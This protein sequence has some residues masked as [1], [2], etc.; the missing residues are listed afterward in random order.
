[1]KK[2]LIKYKSL[3]VEVKAALWF[4]VCN[5]INKAISMIIVPIYTRLLTT[6][7]YGTYTVFQSWLNLFI[8]L[9]T[10]EIGRG[11]YS[12]GIMKYEDDSDRYSSAMLGL[13]NA[14][15]ILF[16]VVYLFAIPFF[17]GVLEMNTSLVMS[18]FAYL[19]FYPA[20][21]FWCIK[22]RFAYKYK[23]MVFGTLIVAFLSPIIGVVGIVGLGLKSEAAILSK[24][25]VQGIA[26]LGVYVLFLKKS[27][28]PFIKVYWKEVLPYSLTLLP[29]LLSTMIL[30]QADRLM[31]NRM[32][33]TSEAAIY[34]VAYSVSM[35]T[36]LLNTAINNA[37]VPWMYR[38]LKGK[39]Y[40]KIEPV[41]DGLQMIVGIINLTLIVFAPEVIAAFA[42]PQYKEAIF[43]I[44]PIT[45]S[46]YFMF[47]FQRY[48]NVEMYYEKTVS[49][50]IMSIL[51]ALFNIVLNYFCILKWGYLAAG[52]TTLVSYILFCI[53][54]YFIVYKIE[55]IKCEG[56]TIFHAK[57]T[58]LAGIGFLIIS[59]GIMWLYNYA[60][61]RYIVA[62]GLAVI[63]YKKK[64]V[65]MWMLKN[66]KQDTE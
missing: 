34:S 44:P 66:K 42:P 1:M 17:N 13:S 55:K 29:Y 33:G 21:E 18:M 38:R 53:G 41:A 20:W 39:Q 12:L 56:N 31:I 23:R 28:T 59:F 19:L 47:I 25:V 27:P 37:F 35:L 4:V 32:V 51:V 62:A 61:V 22:Q 2:L 15:T 64:D 3:S 50:S 26:A 63:A 45:A 10:L 43:I 46:V 65:F 40:N 24:L 30:N 52:Y 11:H 57:R 14:T 48:I 58:I 49:I 16:L 8:I 9:M 5:F 54:H 36:Q 6:A 7:E 60:V